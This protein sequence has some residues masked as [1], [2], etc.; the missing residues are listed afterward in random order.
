MII[1]SGNLRTLY[2][3]FNASFRDGFGQAPSDHEPIRMETSSE[4]EEEE[5]G[6]LGQWPGLQE[7]VGERVLR[8]L[9][10]HGYAVRNRTFESTLRVS[11][12]KIEDDR[13]GVY[14]PLFGELG[15]AAAAHPCELVYEAL[16]GGFEGLCYDGQY[17]FDTDHP[18]PDGSVSNVVAGGAGSPWFLLDCSR[19]IKPII[20]QKRRDYHMTYMDSLDDEKVFMSNEFRYGVDGRSNTG[21]GLWQLA[22]GSRLPLTVERFQTARESMMKFVGDEGRPLGIMPTHLVVGPDNEHEALQILNAERLANGASNVYRG[23]AQIICTPWI[24]S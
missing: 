12:E 18:T 4:T 17:F 22:F 14:A 5:Y 13:L 24:T 20:Y 16:V 1:N 10:E 6:W 9:A 2:R 19:R 23:K 8:G 15:R 21:Y 11:R 3:A 7:W